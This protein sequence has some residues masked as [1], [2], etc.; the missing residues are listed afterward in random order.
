MKTVKLAYFSPTGTTRR[1]LES[2]A[3]GLGATDVEHIDATRPEERNKPLRTADNE[4]LVIGV[5]VYMGRVPALLEQWLDTIEAHD[6]PAVCVVVYGNRAY[7]NALLELKDITAARGCIPVAGAAYIG[8]HSFSDTN[9]PTAQGRPDAAD[10]A[11][12]QEFGKAIRRKLDGPSSKLEELVVPGTHPYG[13]VTE[14]WSVDFIEVDDRCTQCGTCADACPMEAIDT[15]DSTAVDQERCITCCA[16]IK[17][18]QQEARSMKPGP[19]MDARHRLSTL[20]GEPK[21]P[22]HFL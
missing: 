11:D 18:C 6:T 13:G 19:V 2:I 22:E 21:Q 12:A 16:C 9:E 15:H 3:S 1:V 20:F 14:L 17:T 8:E 7:E 5:P 4:V 10:L